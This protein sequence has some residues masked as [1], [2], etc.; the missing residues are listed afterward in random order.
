MKGIKTQ[1]N[2]IKGTSAGRPKGRKNSG[3]SKEIRNLN[4]GESLLIYGD[5]LSE[6][7]IRGLVGYMRKTE[8]PRLQAY[9]SASG[10]MVVRNRTKR[11]M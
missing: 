8:N 6:T 3:V 2:K 7:S 11:E 1:T 4:V 5:V 10:N 9:K